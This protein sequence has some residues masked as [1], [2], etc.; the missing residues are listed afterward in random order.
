MRM[1]V[2]NVSAFF[3]RLPKRM[4]KKMDI[5]DSSREMDVHRVILKMG[6]QVDD[7]FIYFNEML[8]RVMRAQFGRVKLNSVMVLNELVSQFRI[9]QLTLEAKAAGSRNSS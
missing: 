7:G 2:K 1:K 4:Q 3:Q 9:L 6:I 8:Y 5:D